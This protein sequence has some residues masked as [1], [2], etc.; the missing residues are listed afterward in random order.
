MSKMSEWKSEIT[1][2][3]NG[4]DEGMDACRRDMSVSVILDMWW[5]GG[6]F[7]M[8]LERE[9]GRILMVWRIRSIWQGIDG[10][11]ESVRIL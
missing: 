10:N 3:D 8:I 1:W 9:E 6:N 7:N 11:D 4:E 5:R 2:K